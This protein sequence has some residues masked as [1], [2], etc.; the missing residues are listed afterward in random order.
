MSALRASE[1]ASP[2]FNMHHSLI[3]QGTLICVG[4]A[5]IF[6]FRSQQRRREKDEQAFSPTPPEVVSRV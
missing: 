1:D 4:T 2:P 3:F 6:F 5:G